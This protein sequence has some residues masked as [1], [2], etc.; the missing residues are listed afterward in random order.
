MICT[1]FLPLLNLNIPRNMPLYADIVLPLYQPTYTFEVAAGCDLA[2]GDAVAVQFGAKALYTGIVWRLHDHRPDVKQIKV[3]SRKLYD[4]PLLSARQ[5]EFWEWIADYYMC[6]LGEV[7]RMALP[8]LIKPRAADEEAF[9]REQF[10]PRTESFVRLAREISVDE[11]IRLERR[12]P[13]QSELIAQLDE[14]GELRRAECDAAAVAALRKKGMVEI[15]ERE[16]ERPSV[17]E[18]EYVLPT[19]TDCQQGALEKILYDFSQVQT[20]LLRGVTGSGKTE[21]YMH[22]IARTLAEGGDVLYLVPEI[23][24]TTQLLARVKRVFGERVT[25]YHSKLTAVRRAE[26]YRRLVRSEGGELVLGTRSALFLPMNN[27]RLIIV[28]EEHDSSYKQ[29][30]PAPRYQGRDAA[31]MLARICGANCLLGSATPS[32][33]SFVRAATGKYREVVISERYGGAQQPEVIIS[34]TIR[35]AK[36]G[37]HKS[38]FNKVLLDKIA[39]R[40][41]RG[42]QVL[43]F[44]NRRGVSPYVSCGNC[45]WTARCP[46]CNVSLTL[47]GGNRLTCHYCGY[48]EPLPRKCPSCKGAEVAPMGFGTEKI[49]QE[50]TS[51]FP[52]ARVARLDRD[53]LTSESACNRIVEAFERG[54]TDILVGTQIITKGFDFSRVTL[55]GVLNADNLLNAPDYRASERAFQTLMQFAGRGG[56]GDERGEVV[57]QTAEPE[58]PI[59]RQVAL[60]DYEGLAREQSAERQ[61]FFYPPYSRLVGL[62]MRYRDAALLHRAARELSAALRSRFAERVLG[63]TVPPVDRVRG[64]H[65]VEIVLKIESGASFSRARKILREIL[66]EVM[67]R[68]EYRNIITICNV[69][70]S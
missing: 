50:I 4:T 17:G 37:E 9:E 64:E 34:D 61:Q 54:E 28:D 13:R 46:H 51:L 21:I 69:D 48:G 67:H 42:E 8:S 40:L 18:Q 49:E 57:I 5:M 56:R 38:H 52:E 68:R 44:Q 2:V 41:E 70:A 26:I 24:M 22:L 58:H 19:L 1:A 53:T 3:I 31:V 33:E 16:A 6:T 63:P 43:L 62:T 29:T 15:S 45:G 23:A 55:V 14:R 11:R 30:E 36:R 27:L 32:V 12:A 60:G 59:L 35:A 47:H 7:M 66:H 65:I 10:R 20:V 25:P 39:E